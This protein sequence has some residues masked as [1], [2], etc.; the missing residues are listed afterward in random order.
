MD[1]S[2]ELTQRLK[3][4]SPSLVRGIASELENY[5]EI[6]REARH[7]IQLDSTQIGLHDGLMELLGYVRRD[8]LRIDQGGPKFELTKEGYDLYNQFVEEGLCEGHY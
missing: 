5:I 4:L 6:E 7:S 2:K 3:N 8:S 1:T